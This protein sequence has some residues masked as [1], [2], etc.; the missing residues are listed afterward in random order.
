MFKFKNE[1]FK[2]QIQTALKKGIIGDQDVH[3]KDD[4]YTYLGKQ[5]NLTA[6][7]IRKWQSPSNNGPSSF[8]DIRKLEEIFGVSLTQDTNDVSDDKNTPGFESTINI[9]LSH[10]TININIHPEAP[11][12]K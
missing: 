5:L 12:Q 3:S 7:T 8:E 4:I 6:D 1:L 2:A 9:H 10:N 11:E